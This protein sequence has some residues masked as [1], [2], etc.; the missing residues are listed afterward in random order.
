ME[1]NRDLELT[2]GCECCLGLTEEF[3]GCLKNAWKYIEMSQ[4]IEEV[5]NPKRFYRHISVGAWP[6]STRDHGWPIS[7]CTAEG[8][9]ATF[10]LFTSP[11]VYIFLILY[12]PSLSPSDRHHHHHHHHLKPRLFVWIIISRK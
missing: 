4:V 12:N 6:F 11:L 8:L 1:L 7:D 2:F 3:E 10:S 9:K 5:E